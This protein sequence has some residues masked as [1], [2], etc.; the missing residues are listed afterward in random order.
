[1]TH[2]ELLGV[3]ANPRTITSGNNRSV[4]ITVV[5]CWCPG[6]SLIWRPPPRHGLRCSITKQQLITIERPPLLR[7]SRPFS[8]CIQRRLRAK[9]A[10][11]ASFNF[12]HVWQKWNS[13]SCT[14]HFSRRTRVLW[15]VVGS[16][17][18]FVPFVLIIRLFWNFISSVLFCRVWWLI[19]LSASVLFVS[20]LS[21][22]LTHAVSSACLHITE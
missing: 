10:Q 13:L 16:Y 20:Q 3:S 9:G 21:V 2:S 17:L 4:L 8:I 22:C 18:N 7:T 12:V 19:E 1:M 15:S 5:W 6:Q 11:V 14:S